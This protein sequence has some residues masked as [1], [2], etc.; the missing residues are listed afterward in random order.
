[1]KAFKKATNLIFALLL[2]ATLCLVSFVACDKQKDDGAVPVNYAK[3]NNFEVTSSTDV[4][5][6]EA[7]KQEQ[8]SATL[9]YPSDSSVKPRYGFVFFVGSAIAT[10]K[11]A[12]LGNALAKQGYVVAMPIVPLNMTYAYYESATKPAAEKV[13]AKYPDVKFFVGGHSQGG[14]AAMRFAC[15][16]ED[17]AKGVV[18]LSPL[19]YEAYPVERKDYDPYDPESDRYERDEDGKIIYKFDTLAESSLPTLLLEASGDHV[20]T[21]DMK[22]DAKSRMPKD[23]DCHVIKPGSHMSFSTWDDDNTLAF[24][25]N[26]GDG[27]TQTD[28][29]NQRVLTVSYVLDFLQITVCG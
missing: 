3:T 24:F 6:P 1:M 2:A 11:Y 22:A 26:D 7:E 17:K 29:E 5:N 16:M 28:K 25:N 21:D 20:L 4:L 15:E 8:I 27:L 10:D 9:Y 13:M 14:G 23:A 12:Y 19:C 18:F